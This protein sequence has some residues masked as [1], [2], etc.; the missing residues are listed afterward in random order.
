MA[1][2]SIAVSCL[3]FLAGELLLFLQYAMA[4]S[5]GKRTEV[6]WSSEKDISIASDA[7]AKMRVVKCNEM[8][9]HGHYYRVGI[10]AALILALLSGVVPTLFAQE[11]TFEREYTY[12]ASELDSRIS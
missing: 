8:C 1:A 9:D 2:K 4:L 11:I 3:L 6:N 10:A 12:K 5:F 7:V